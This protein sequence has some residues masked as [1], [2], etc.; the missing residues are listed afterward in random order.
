MK[1][2]S[3][4]PVGANNHGKEQCHMAAVESEDILLVYMEYMERDAEIGTD[5]ESTEE[6]GTELE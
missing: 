3:D 6:T 4:D 5:Q 1:K 2:L